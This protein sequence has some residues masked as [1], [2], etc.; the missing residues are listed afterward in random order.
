LTPYPKLRWFQYR[1]RTLFVLTTLVAIGMSWV[2]V[3]MQ[4]QRREGAAAQ[5]IEKAGGDVKTE[6]TWLG[7][8]LRDDSLVRVIS[9]DLGGRSVADAELVHL[10]GMSQLQWLSLYNTRVTDAGL[11]HLR[12]LGQLQTLNLNR[13]EVTDAGLVHL[14]GLRQLQS[15]SFDDTKITDAGLA[16][17]EG[18]HQLQELWLYK[19]KV[20]DAGMKKLQQVLPNCDI[21]HKAWKPIH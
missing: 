3:T 11:V 13:T 12:G 10:Q 6:A 4:Q 2:A 15:L 8:V 5:A 21:T 20:T 1:L 18:L 19:T 17:L 9:V 16:H 7:R 14:E